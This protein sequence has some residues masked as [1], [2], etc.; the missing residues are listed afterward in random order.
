MS[1]LSNLYKK[2]IILG[3]KDIWILLEL[4]AALMITAMLLFVIPENINQES[5]IYIQDKTGI[6]ELMV[7]Q[8]SGEKRVAKTTMTMKAIGTFFGSK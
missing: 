4:G 1:K 8:M 7:K 3:F 6:F 2:D 5:S